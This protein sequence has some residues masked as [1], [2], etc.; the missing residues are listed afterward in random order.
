MPT[1]HVSSLL[2]KEIQ[3]NLLPLFNVL[4]HDGYALHRELVDL[5]KALDGSCTSSEQFDMTSLLAEAP[6]ASVSM[7]FQRSGYKLSLKPESV[8]SEA[9]TLEDVSREDPT[10]PTK[11]KL[12]SNVE[13]ETPQ[14]KDTPDVKVDDTAV[15]RDENSLEVAPVAE[16]VLDVAPSMG[17]RYIAASNER[18]SELL[19]AISA[20]GSTFSRNDVLL[21]ILE[22]GSNAAA[23]NPRD[24][25]TFSSLHIL[26]SWMLKREQSDKVSLLEGA[27][28]LED[29]TNYSQQCLLRSL[30][31]SNQATSTGMTGWLEYGRS[32]TLDRLADRPF[33]VLRQIA[34]NFGRMNQWDDA[35]SVLLSLVV[36]CEQHLPQFHPMT[37]T[38]MI[39]LAIASEKV[40]KAMFSERLI[41]RV[42]GRLSS[43]LSKAESVYT[44]HLSSCSPPGGKPGEPVFRIEHGRDA[45][46]MLREFVSSLRLQLGRDMAALVPSD[47]DVILTNH[48]F[49]ADSLLVLSNCITAARSVLGSGSGPG[50][51]DDGT[52]YVELAFAHYQLVFNGFSST[53]GLDHPSTIKSAYGLARCLRE[54]GETKKARQLLS[55]VV[56]FTERGGTQSEAKEESMEGVESSIGVQVNK[57]GPADRAETEGAEPPLP[58]SVTEFLPFAFSAKLSGV[59]H[60]V[61]KHTSSALCLWLMAILSLDQSTSEDGREE[62]FSY[63][64]AASVSLQSA[65]NRVSRVDDEATKTMCIRFLAMIEDEAMKISEPTYE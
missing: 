29:V 25:S 31:I 52:E 54:L 6:C 8:A 24:L 48:C 46:A 47:H 21:A 11:S 10:T 27:G 16:E 22:Q 17:S 49:V 51:D 4:G 19:Q 32:S 53:M 13:G 59:D 45:C 35:E 33:I 30:M 65:L 7:S 15:L 60:Q 14:T 62:A 28:N 38:A 41:S 57:E 64:H 40:G 37:L 18:R 42:A 63:L 26:F 34:Y 5:Q 3:F 61:S 23:D 58:R 1:A 44:S 2:I 9:P 55:I 36:R 20:N 43:Y 50:P 12:L 39:D 56:S